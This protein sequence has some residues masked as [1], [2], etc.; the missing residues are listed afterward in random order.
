MQIITAA[1]FSWLVIAISEMVPGFAFESR[2]DR[3]LF[4]MVAWLCGYQLFKKGDK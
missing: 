2:A 3:A 1:A 4:Y